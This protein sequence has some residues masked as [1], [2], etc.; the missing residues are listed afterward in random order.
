MLFE[1][2]SFVHDKLGLVVL[3]HEIFFSVE[4]QLVDHT[5]V[6]NVLLIHEHVVV[7]VQN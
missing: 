2:H 5:N 6:L 4:L 3:F 7:V 1:K